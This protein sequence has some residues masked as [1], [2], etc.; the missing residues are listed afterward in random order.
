MIPAA[1]SARPTPCKKLRPQATPFLSPT[2]LE[3]LVGTSSPQIL[4]TKTT[5]SGAPSL[6]PH[7]GSNFDEQHTFPPEPLLPDTSV[8]TLESYIAA[9]HGPR[10]GYPFTMPWRRWDEVPEPE[11]APEWLK[12]RRVRGGLRRNGSPHTSHENCRYYLAASH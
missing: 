10:F 1:D 6:T 4:P 3:P 11:K 7:T 8:P 12:A 9:A 2:I 5:S